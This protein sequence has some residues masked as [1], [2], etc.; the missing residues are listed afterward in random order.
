MNGYHLIDLGTLAGPAGESRIYA[1]N[2]DGVAV[3]ESDTSMSK[4][5][6]VRWDAGGIVDL[7]PAAE[8]G[9]A[10]GIT[11]ESPPR[12]AGYADGRAILWE[13]TAPTDLHPV[14]AAHFPDITAS[15]ARDVSA[16]GFVAGKAG[17]HAFRMD[18]QTQTIVEVGLP[19]ADDS[20]AIA[21]NELGH[22]AGASTIAG[23]THA[24]FY[25]GQQTTQVDAG[26]GLHTKATGL[27]DADLLVADITDGPGSIWFTP[28]DGFHQFVS[29]FGAEGVN[30]AG[31]VVGSLNG[32]NLHPALL[33]HGET[34][35]VDLA[36]LVAP[37]PGVSLTRAPAINAG[38]FIAVN[39]LFSE[40][41]HA[42]LL[43]PR[44]T[45][46][47]RLP[48]PELALLV[49]TFL[50]GGTGD[51]GGVGHVGRVPIHVDPWGPLRPLSPAQRDVLV[52]LAIQRL[53]EHVSD[54][55]ARRF[56]EGGGLQVIRA[57]VDRLFEQTRVPTEV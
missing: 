50:F 44:P 33:P 45:L 35:P 46:S 9:R 31:D 1:L 21:V 30:A 54:P 25:D 10:T 18:L 7:S 40:N 24:F 22:V 3:G 12:V 47:A 42:Y 5:H 28:Q 23:A 32:S 57:A 34:Q 17:S 55:D 19:G 56:A 41:A 43:D 26:A 49:A 4:A 11:S 15:W 29:S 20:D 2:D 53:A 6:A 27:N 37:E 52:G 36:T 51:A 39:G 38:G 13:D 48:Q 14:L 8:G 16:S